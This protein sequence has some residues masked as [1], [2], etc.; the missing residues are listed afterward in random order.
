MLNLGLIPQPNGPNNLFNSSKYAQK[1]RDDKGAFRIDQNTNLGS[2]FLYYFNDDYF[3]NDPFPNGG[4]T[5]PAAS[6]AYNGTTSGRAQLINLGHT[7]NFGSFS[8]NEIRLSYVRNTLDFTEAQ[9]GVGPTYSLAALG[10]GAY[11]LIAWQ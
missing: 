5:V 7:K 2:F 9:G 6:F 11:L 8:V 1:L 3:V 4:A 10:F